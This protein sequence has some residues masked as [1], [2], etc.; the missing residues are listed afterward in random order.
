M[1]APTPTRL[2]LLPPRPRAGGTTD[3]EAAARYFGEG[4]EAH[5]AGRPA[6]ALAAFERARAL[7][8][9]HPNAAAACAALLGEQGRHRAAWEALLPAR[10]ALLRSADGA[11]NLGT[12]AEQCGLDAEAGAAYTHA[13]AAN[14]DHVPALNNQAQ[15][16]ARAGRFA[17]AL[18][19]LRRCAELAPRLPQLWGHWADALLAS[20]DAPGAL[21]ALAQAGAH[22]PNEL[23][24]AVRH[25]VAAACGSGSLANLATAQNRLRALPPAAGPLLQDCLGASG[26]GQGVCARQ[27]GGAPAQAPPS[28]DAV[29]L[30]LRHAWR[31]GWDAER[32]H[33]L[34]EP[35]CDALCRHPP[36]PHARSAEEAAELLALAHRLPLPE[37]LRQ[38]LRH[39]IAPV[40]PSPGEPPVR[41]FELSLRRHADGRLRIGLALSEIPS[42]DHAAALAAALGR[43]DG[44]RFVFHVYAASVPGD[45]A[46]SDLL[47][48]AGIHVVELAHLRLAERIERIRL[49]GLD[50][51]HDLCDGAPWCLPLGRWRMARVQV[52]HPAREA[53]LPQEA[54]DYRLLRDDHGGSPAEGAWLRGPA[55]LLGPA[56]DA[57][58]W[59]RAWTRLA[60]RAHQQ[61]APAAFDATVPEAAP[62]AP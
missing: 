43:H 1:S 45:L 22:H 18:P 48:G 7:A 21:R 56:H 51:L 41:P 15:R 49:D 28:R 62:P 12:V 38:R 46:R 58:G 52:Q 29:L 9:E 47:R 2:P 4:A 54:W 5:A 33:R 34:L 57:A 60:E 24:L 50:L 19:A 61:Q 30:L 31:H 10:D 55:G 26:L 23:L 25:A 53:L 44:A 3:R 59:A 37:A 6:E 40:L 8:P 20:G 16:L 32:C 11:F 27:A 35:A 17:E 36:A 42:I 39:R 14:P 13:L